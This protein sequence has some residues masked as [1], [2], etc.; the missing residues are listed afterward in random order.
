MLV[1]GVLVETASEGNRSV[2]AISCGC[3]GILADAEGSRARGRRRHRSLGKQTLVAKCEE[4]LEFLADH[5]EHRK[6]RQLTE[7][8]TQLRDRLQ[9]EQDTG[10]GGCES[11]R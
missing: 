1:G 8:I 7:D 3:R 6:L 10:N 2:P 11:P 9:L 5:D 4:L